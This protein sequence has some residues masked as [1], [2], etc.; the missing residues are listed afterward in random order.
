[1]QRLSIAFAR[2]HTDATPR[3]KRLIRTTGNTTFSWMTGEREIGPWLR[4]VSPTSTASPRGPHLPKGFLFWKHMLHSVQARSGQQKTDLDCVMYY[5]WPGRYK[6][7]RNGDHRSCG[8]EH[9]TMISCG[10]TTAHYPCFIVAS[11]SVVLG[12]CNRQEPPKLCVHQGG[13][14]EKRTSERCVTKGLATPGPHARYFMFITQGARALNQSDI[15]R[16]WPT[17]CDNRPARNVTR[18]RCLVWLRYCRPCRIVLEEH[19]LFGISRSILSR[20]M[21]GKH[22]LA[23]LSVHPP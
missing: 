21:G 2:S 16:L 8:S 10:G 17:S 19:Q 15:G 12:G 6:E 20:A 7:C 1:M 13:I 3:P 14:F 18:R 5:F 11:P 23:R 9:L 22:I 4:W